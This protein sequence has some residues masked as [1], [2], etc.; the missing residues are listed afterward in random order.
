[1][2]ILTLAVS[3]LL[4]TGCST[5]DKYLGRTTAS[6]TDGNFAWDSNKNHENLDASY[7]KSA[8]GSVKARLKTTATTP[9]A[10]MAAAAADNAAA[11][12]N[13]SEIL[14]ELL[15]ILKQG[16]TTGS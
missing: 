8:D 1:M 7:E 5:V 2:K 14:K 10:A 3:F 12:K 9:E 13:F 4:F 11:H 15:P 16:A 6:Y